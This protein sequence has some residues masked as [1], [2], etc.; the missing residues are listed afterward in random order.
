[1][2]GSNPP[3]LEGRLAFPNLAPAA[4]DL[5][6][7]SLALN[8]TASTYGAGNRTELALLYLASSSLSCDPDA[9]RRGAAILCQVGLQC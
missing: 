8:C 4:Q 6:S 5:L 1:M 2:H 3:P 9:L 7:Q